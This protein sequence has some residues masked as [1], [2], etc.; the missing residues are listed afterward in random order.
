MLP[1]AR[2]L[3]RRE[4]YDALQPHL[5]RGLEQR[6]LEG[7]VDRLYVDLFK[8][9]A[10]SVDDVEN[11]RPLSRL[12]RGIVENALEVESLLKLERSILSEYDGSRRMVFQIRRREKTSV[13]IEAV[14]IPR[15]DDVTLCLSSQS[16]CALACSF[17]A[18]GLLGFQENL[19]TA[20][21]LEQ[22]AW[23]ERQMGKRV[24]DIVFM[25]M[26]EP[27]LNYDAVIAAAHRLTET[28]CAQIS[29]K[30]IVLSTA[31]VVPQI[32]RYAREQQPFALYFSITS[33][34]PEK[35]RELMPIENSYPLD[36]LVKAIRAYLESRRWN[37]RATLEY[38]AIPDV[39]M[40]DEDVEAIGKVFG[41]LPIILNVI[42][43]NAT[44]GRYRPPNW[45]E[46]KR[47]TTKLRRLDIAVKIRF[48]GAKTERGGCGQL[49]ADLIE[50]VPL[51][52]HHLAPPG[53]FSD[54][55]RSSQ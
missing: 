23:A 45:T 6:H 21:I 13:K 8:H 25:G 49:A 34:I 42:P 7:F 5:G 32:H 17:C 35:R 40:D 38:V 1:N 2:G 20:E 50:G 30:R 52:G 36:E 3:Q 29:F 28:D 51:S 55:A 37:P 10:M 33:A 12:R 46:V 31:G 9:H 43:Y 39:N 18:T 53:I 44:D 14:A 11:L 16:G 4:L 48:S 24:T 41:S 15:R 19:T 22:H 47:F 26:G 27:L 54:L